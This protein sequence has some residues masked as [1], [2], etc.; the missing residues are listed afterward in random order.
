VH[1]LAIHEDTNSSLALLEDSRVLFA[2]A[3]ERF[4]RNKFQHGMPERC[5]SYVRE[6]HGKDLRNADVLVAGNPTHFLA[7]L[8]GFLPEEEHDLFGPMQKAYLS[9]QDL[10]PASPVL[11]TASTTL[12]AAAL[13]LKIGRKVHFV[14]HHTAH[15]YSA[16]MTAGFPECVTV[17]A[18]NMGDGFA[19]KVFDC[20]D[21][22][23]RELYGSSAVK[24]PGQFYGEITQL[25]GF[26]V[27][28]AGKVTGLAA[29]SDWR[30]AYPLVSRL[31]SLSRDGRDFDVA[32]LWPRSRSRGIFAD[33]SR[34]SPGEISAA[35]QRRFEDVMV[36]YVKA[37]VAATGRRKVALA[38]GIFANVK[39][40]QRIMELPEV[41][42]VFIHPA[43]SDQGIAMGAALHYLAHNQGLKPYSIDHVYFGPSYGEEEIGSALEANKLVYTRPAD[44]EAVVAKA[45]V[46]SK[47]VARFFGAMEYGPRALGH[48]TVMYRPDD[49]NVNIWLNRNLKRSEFM[50]FAPVTL[51]EHAA[52]CYIN[53]DKAAHAARYM[54]MCFDC[55]EP[56]ARTC[57]GVVHVDGTARPQVIDRETDPAYHR[58]VELFYKE[59]GIPSVIN[60]SFNMHGEPIVCTPEDA[61]EAFLDSKM[62]YLAIG[63]F[64][65]ERQKA[66]S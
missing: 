33:L 13:R 6:A 60:T 41:D 18:D 54:T 5:L 27:L 66:N 1:L 57:S 8:P 29:Y 12:S 4:T 23:C 64:L 34:F 50:P 30:P 22:T 56:M 45:L 10:L 14:D 38:G 20:S 2:A 43:M 46:E 37:A 32:P 53:I 11:R 17:S 3:E 58:I 51:A 49:W 31:F 61:I 24:S 48:R 21:G 65:V 44:M 62:D 7:R 59:T 25:L 42:E 35:T 40:N 63:P 16:Y 19:A 36:G 9:F 28:M 26:H 47:V 55:T 52:E 39:L 15:G